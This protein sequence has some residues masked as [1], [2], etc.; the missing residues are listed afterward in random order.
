MTSVCPGYILYLL[1]Q[2]CTV[3]FYCP[4]QS[5]MLF[6]ST[7]LINTASNNMD[8]KDQHRLEE[9]LKKLVEKLDFF[10]FLVKFK[11]VNVRH[12]LE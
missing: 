10:F 12:I 3:L 1:L 6:C 11:W 8:S 4:Y 7:V 9:R 2:G 5:K